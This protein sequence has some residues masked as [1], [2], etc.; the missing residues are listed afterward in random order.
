LLGGEGGKSAKVS[1]GTVTGSPARS[2]GSGDC[3]Q[4]GQMRN[5]KDSSRDIQAELSGY[6][7]R[8]LFIHGGADAEG[9]SGWAKVF[10]PF[11]KAAKAEHRHL[12]IAGADHDYHDLAAKRQAIEAAVAFLAAPGA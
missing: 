4:T 7:G 11:L 1:P 3:P 5:L 12:A 2:A 10:E 9:L 6:Q 8:L